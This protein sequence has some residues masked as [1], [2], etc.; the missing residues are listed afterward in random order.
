V[1]GRVLP[2][3]GRGH[4]AIALLLPWYA[5][6]TLTQDESLRVHLHLAECAACRGEVEA[7]RALM[8]DAQEDA[9]VD[10]AELDRDWQ[11]L[12]SRVHATRR[13][14]AVRDRW[15]RLQSAWRETAPWMRIALGA[16]AAMLVVL[17][18]F[19]FRVERAPAPPAVYR[20]LSSSP[21]VAT[22]ANRVLVVFDSRMTEAQ[23]RSLLS[24]VHG[25]IVDGP[26]DAGAFLVATEPGQAELV[27][28]T[29]RAS[30]GVEIAELLSPVETHE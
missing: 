11:R 16:Q 23:M 7:M 5:N 4:R 18:V 22:K 1:N 12:R 13:A 28:N 25:R 17:G 20:T 2:F 21:A 8:S 26:N 10:A 29:L 24:Q 14:P 30:P 9:P 3:E 6:G 15:S 27:R 19:V